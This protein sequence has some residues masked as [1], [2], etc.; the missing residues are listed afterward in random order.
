MDVAYESCISVLRISDS[1]ANNTACTERGGTTEAVQAQRIAEIPSY[2][3]TMSSIG[4]YSDISLQQKTIA[5]YL[6]PESSIEVSGVGLFPGEA[7]VLEYSTLTNPSL[8]GERFVILNKTVVN[9]TWANPDELFM[10]TEDYWQ[11]NDDKGNLKDIV[12]GTSQETLTFVPCSTKILLDS[13][14]L[15]SSV[16]EA[17]EKDIFSG[18]SPDQVCLLAQLA[19]PGDL[20]PYATLQ[21]CQDFLSSIPMSCN[22]DQHMLQGNTTYCRFLHATAA[23]IAPLVHCQHVAIDSTFCLQKDC[24]NQEYSG[25]YGERVPG[26]FNSVPVL[27]VTLLIVLVP[28][29]F[30]V[31]VMLSGRWQDLENVGQD[32]KG[33]VLLSSSEGADVRLSVTN[34]SYELQDGTIL[35]QGVSFKANMGD[36]V[37]LM[38]PS[39]AGK[40]TLLKSLAKQLEGKIGGDVLVYKDGTLDKDQH[41]AYVEQN[42]AGLAMALPNLTVEESL[43]SHARTVALIKGR[44]YAEGMKDLLDDLCDVLSLKSFLHTELK[45]LSGGQ[46]KRW[47]VA[48]EVLNKPSILLLDEP[49]SGLDSTAALQLMCA[50]K[51]LSKK[52]II[53][54]TIHQPSNSVIDMFSHVLLLQKGGKMLQYASVDSQIKAIDTL[55]RSYRLFKEKITCLSPHILNAVIIAFSELDP[56]RKGYILARDSPE[57]HGTGLS[58]DMLGSIL[59]AS[60]DPEDL[61]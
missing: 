51:G 3:N 6:V 21:D 31:F 27:I 24:N 47:R 55:E 45:V 40:T 35:V 34:Y 18:V 49:T 22:D 36:I 17:F 14:T 33:A 60:S 58:L 5:T 56:A 52:M 29:C 39:G 13:T 10:Y 25:A 30:H 20:F 12:K 9:Y 41:I 19:C 16:A 2:L 50:L 15:D 57:M 8:N 46:Q 28:S 7:E 48:K 38:G 32:G 43:I 42:P 54:C 59:A 23:T 37:A 11:I 1:R 53:V 44:E 61:E 4:E 26:L